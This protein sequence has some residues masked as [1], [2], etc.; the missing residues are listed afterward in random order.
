M[1]YRRSTRNGYGSR[2]RSA[3]PAAGRRR[4]TGRR[5]TRRSTRSRSG[6]QTIR[7]VLETAPQSPVSRNPFQPVIEAKGRGK[8]KL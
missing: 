4:S 5:V 6:G 8:A 3:R 7:L 2:Y 1:A